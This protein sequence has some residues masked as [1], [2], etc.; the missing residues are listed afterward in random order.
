M[1]YL[2]EIKDTKQQVVVRPDKLYENVEI[3]SHIPIWENTV[4]GEIYNF[5]EIFIIRYLNNN[6]EAFKL[7]IEPYKNTLVI[8]DLDEISCLIDVTDK[9]ES[10]YF[11][12]YD[13]S[14]LWEKQE[15]SYQSCVGGFI[16]LKGF[17]SEKN[18]NRMVS[19]WNL[20]HHNKAI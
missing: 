3:I 17:I 8:N 10:D 15:F 7:E 14:R 2:A 11:Y 5:T 12:I 9:F 20:N 6:F 4:T 13:S 18:Y 16:P 1:Y 19:I